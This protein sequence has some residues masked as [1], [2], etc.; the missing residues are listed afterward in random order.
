MFVRCCGRG[1]YWRQ[2]RRLIPARVLRWRERARVSTNTIK[3]SD[4]RAHRRID[5]AELPVPA[6]VSIPDRPPIALVDLSS[7]GALLELPFQLQPETRVTLAVSTPKE[8]AVVPFQVL[9]CWV[10]DLKGGVRYRAAGAFEQTLTLPVLQPEAPPSPK[11]RLVATLEG[12]L[13]TT[14]PA[15][16]ASLGA[17]FHQ[18]VRWVLDSVNRGDAAGLIAIKIKA[19]LGQQFR[20]LVIHA[21]SDACLRDA[22]TSARFFGYDFRSAEA[23]TRDDRRILRAGAQM[24]ALLDTY[25]REEAADANPAPGLFTHMPPIVLRSIAEWQEYKRSA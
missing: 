5:K 19:H 21:A 14:K 22:R 15:D 25:A 1:V 24:I 18:L 4:R 3:P 16:L 11:D 20:S 2:T 10:A 17:G 7:G 13:N 12:F 23:L 6:Q 9:R 8:N